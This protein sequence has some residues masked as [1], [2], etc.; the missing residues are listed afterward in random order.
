MTGKDIILVTGGAGFLGQHVVKLLQ[1]NYDDVAEI[2]IFDCKAYTNKLGRSKLGFYV[3][4]NSQDHIG[5]GSQ[6]Y[7]LS[8]WNHIEVTACD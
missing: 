3:P 2:R 6:Y 8:D 1:E 5:T 4:F 7:H